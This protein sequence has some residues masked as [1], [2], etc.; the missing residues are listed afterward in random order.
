[1]DNGFSKALDPIAP[2]EHVITQDT[3]TKGSL[4]IYALTLLN[5]GLILTGFSLDFWE[6]DLPLYT[7]WLG[8]V[9]M[10]FG[11]WMLRKENKR[12][13]DA[14]RSSII[15]LLILAA[16]YWASLFPDSSVSPTR[17]DFFMAISVVISILQFYFLF[18][19]LS[20]LVLRFNNQKLGKELMYCFALKVS[21]YIATFVAFVLPDLSTLAFL[22]AMLI[23]VYQL[24]TINRIKLYAKL[25]G[26]EITVG[27]VNKR[28]WLTLFTYVL[29]VIGCTFGLQ[30][31]VNSPNPVAQL[32]ENDI[33]ADTAEIRERL[34]SFGMP[35]YVLSDL[36]DDEVRLFDSIYDA[37]TG[38]YSGSSGEISDR[39]GG[40]LEVTGF[41]GVM[42]EGRI[43]VLFF[44]RWITL[45]KHTCIDLLSIASSSE[46][47]PM[48]EPPNERGLSLYDKDGNTYSQTV[49][50]EGALIGDSRCSDEIFQYFTDTTDMTDSRLVTQIQFRLYQHYENQ[51]GYIALDT[52]AK[53]RDEP[54][55]ISRKATY[56]H[57]KSLFNR[58]YFNAINNTSP[59]G[60]IRIKD[61]PG[62]RAFCSD[63]FGFT[64]EYWPENWESE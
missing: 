49:L 48:S 5:W 41:F 35:E 54:F 64:L 19:G 26:H 4:L 45:P 24:D 36:P 42:P 21:V 38:T 57:Q 60:Y 50:N 52:M 8:I 46:H 10:A 13:K 20:S 61:V 51:R 63:L 33:S 28:V 37:Y 58:P 9:L 40:Q 32:Y 53:N 43:R 14:F 7:G 17:A 27:A 29:I 44:Y 2:I 30:Y 34:I 39:D 59:Y 3:K 23:L 22:P 11:L 18:S 6:V 16:N 25:E 56:V 1:M 55:T 31:Y 15:W 62:A 47:F 12:I